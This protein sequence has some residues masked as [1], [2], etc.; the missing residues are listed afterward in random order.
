MHSKFALI[1]LAAAVTSCSHKPHDLADR[2]VAA[3]NVPV[4]AR[5]DYVFDAAA[6]DGMLPPTEAAR[7]D[8]WF[9][10]LNV[11]YGDTIYVD[12]AYADASRAQVAEIAGRYGLVVSPSAPV[13]AGPVGPGSV[14]VVV[15]RTKAMVPNCPNWSVPSQPNYNNRNMSN[16]GC[17]VNSN[18]AAMVANPEDLFHGQASM[19]ASDVQTAVKPVA[20]YRSTAPTG[21]QGLKDVNTKKGD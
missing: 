4:L 7:L 12:G 11:G 6:P 17:A 19:G 5:A 18:L 2:G 20:V 9:G 8:A 16:Y 1:L 10:G 14:R 15:S 3:T 21:T 13:T